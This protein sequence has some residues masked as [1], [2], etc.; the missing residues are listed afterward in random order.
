[1][2]LLSQIEAVHPKLYRCSLEKRD[3]LL[4]QPWSSGKHNIPRSNLAAVTRKR[5]N[6]FKTQSV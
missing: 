4:V 1:M 3:E 2:L 5:I 6:K